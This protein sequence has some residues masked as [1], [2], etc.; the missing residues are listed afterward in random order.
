[1]AYISNPVY[2]G[3]GVVDEA[4]ASA[5]SKQASFNDTY[6]GMMKLLSTMTPLQVANVKAHV[7][8]Y[9]AS[10]PPEEATMHEKNA[11]WAI[12][13]L[14]GRRAAGLGQPVGALATTAAI[15]GIV[16]SVASLGM[17]IWTFA[18]NQEKSK[19]QAAAQKEQQAKTQQ[20]LD[21]Q[22][23]AQKQKNDAANAA[24]A[25]AAKKQAAADAAAAKQQQNQS[26]AQQYVAKGI[27]VPAALAAAVAAPAAGTAAA[28]PTSVGTIAA[29]LGAGAGALFLAR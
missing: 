11:K 27:P 17:G 7:W 15:C 14:D 19:D 2:L 28:A 24:A 29:I 10:L 25:A 4:D 8:K 1:M 6:A 12:K 3:V 22:I 21:M 20:L 18:Q 9:I 5:L 23:A 26:L 13:T 16:A